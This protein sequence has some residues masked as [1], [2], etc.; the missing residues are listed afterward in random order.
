MNEVKNDSGFSEAVRV[1][2]SSTLAFRGNFA[3][4]VDEKGRV[5]LPSDFRKILQSKNETSI[6]LTN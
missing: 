6:V 1:E 3:H 4:T 5:S 2:E